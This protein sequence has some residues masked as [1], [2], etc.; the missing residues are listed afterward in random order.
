MKQNIQKILEEYKSKYN[1]LELDLACGS[2][3]KEDS[4]GVDISDEIGVDIIWDLNQYPWPFEDNSI[5]SI[6]CSH[7]VEHIPHNINNG[8]KRDGLIQFMN[9]LYRILKP[10][11]KVTIIAPYYTSIRAYG[12]PTHQ[13]F[14]CDW[15]F[16]YYN[17]EWRDSNKLS[18]YGII[19]NF[20]SIINYHISEEMSLRSEQV[21]NKA[22]MENWNAVDDIMVELTKI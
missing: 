8:D 19:A 14:I 15:T 18:H 2:S 4:I 3:K 7:Y 20:D 17:K 1:R 5:D 9:E 10:E 21:R 16:L 12:D 6:H 13:R 11:G 22:F